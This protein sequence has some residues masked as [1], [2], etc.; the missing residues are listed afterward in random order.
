MDVQCRKEWSKLHGHDTYGNDDA[1]DADDSEALPRVGVKRPAS[2]C[3]C[4]STTHNHKNCPL[5]KRNKVYVDLPLD[6][7]PESDDSD[8]PP[9]GEGS[10][11]GDEWSSDDS[12]DEWFSDNLCVCG[13]SSKAHKSH[14]PLNSR[15][16]PLVA[17]DDPLPPK[18]TGV[19]YGRK[20]KCAVFKPGDYVCLHTHKLVKQHIPCRVVG[21]SGERYIVYFIQ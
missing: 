6:V 1:D 12:A 9:E 21:V 11:C 17:P 2:K 4:W 7:L 19:P 14:C 10:F 16:Y 18:T 15:N 5:N 8:T 20:R 3:R 13:A